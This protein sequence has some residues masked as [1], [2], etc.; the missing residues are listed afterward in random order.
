MMYYTKDHSWVKVEDDIATIGITNYHQDELGEVVFVEPPVLDS[1]FEQGEEFATIESCKAASD[2]Y[3]PISG[4]VT[5]VNEEIKEFS[6]L[7]NQS[8]EE[9]GWI[10]QMEITHHDEIKKLL[11]AEEYQTIIS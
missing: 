9:K 1:V 6:Q 2:L 11:S 4:K 10:C 8:A 5:Q 7:I 3:A